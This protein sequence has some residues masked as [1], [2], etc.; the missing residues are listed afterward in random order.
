[1]FV[2]TSGTASERTYLDRAGDLLAS[3]WGMVSA[4]LRTERAAAMTA[5]PPVIT[6]A[7][8]GAREK[9][10]RCGPNYAESVEMAYV[11]HTVNSNSY[12][13]ERADDLIRGIYA[14]HVQGRRFCDI[15]YNFLIDRFGR[16][17]EGRYG[18]MDQ[19]V[20][21]AHAMGF[22]TGSTGVAALGDFTSRK[23]PRRVIKAYR[24]LLSWRLDVAHVRPTGTARMESAGGSNTK[25][26]KGDM[27]TVPAVS[28]HRETGYTSCPGARL[29]KRLG[30]IRRGAELR[31]LPKIWD[32][33][34]TPNPARP[35]TTSIRLTATISRE[36]NWTID[37]Y[38]D[39]APAAPFRSYT[40]HGSVIDQT[41]DR[42]DGAL[43]DPQTAP[44]GTYTVVF[45]A[46]GGGE[47]A[48]E[49]P[50][51]LTLQ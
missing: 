16:I 41:W 50:L 10:R 48:R 29:Y 43:L 51:T 49:A 8:W 40:G 44:P 46:T 21:G 13:R 27:V 39:L 35:G 12:S 17:Y 33:D 31:G 47:T 25:Y 7:A 30:A 4:P 26:D 5:Q 3:A 42:T 28:G 22:N 9:M 18:G 34:A 38:N 14:Y 2:N 23:P 20:I 19:P 1:V 15:A 36:M 24:S 6:R 45:R 37:I 11:H 32:H